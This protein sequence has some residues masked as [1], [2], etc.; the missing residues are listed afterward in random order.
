MLNKKR[1]TLTAALASALFLVTST[2]SALTITGTVSAKKYLLSGVPVQ[3]AGTSTVLKIS[4]ETTTAG[5]NL[6][7]CA[8]TMTNFNAGICGTPLS[9][10]G[11]PG[12]TFLSLIDSASL[13]G[14]VIYVLQ[15]V[16]TGAA[17]FSVTIE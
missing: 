17:G 2:A 12:F 8:G 11:G 4:F 9:D 14:Q 10:S 3:S 16:G 7:L 15:D 5:S 13:N 6:E 1:L